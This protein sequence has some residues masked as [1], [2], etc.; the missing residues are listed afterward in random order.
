MTKSEA[1]ASA[2]YNWGINGF[3]VRAKDIHPGGRFRVGFVGNHEGKA[4]VYIL[5]MGADWTEAFRKAE[6]NPMNKEQQEKAAVMRREYHRR[7]A[8]L[9]AN[10][11]QEAAK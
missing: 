2:V 7:A 6:E 4:T 3:A 10:P 5:G 8:E 1:V 9:Q 11:Q